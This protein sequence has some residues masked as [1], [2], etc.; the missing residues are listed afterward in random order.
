MKFVLKWLVNGAIVVSLLMYY[1]DVSLLNA[2]ITATV[3][4]LIAYFVGDQLVLRATNNAIATLADAILAYAILWL[5]ADQMNWNL[6]SGEI[7]VI[8]IVLGIAEW[9]LHRYVM[10]ADLRA[11]AKK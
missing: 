3:L 9:V 8:T 10:Q 6:S 11:Q 1:A 2:L 5:A 7:L 4:T